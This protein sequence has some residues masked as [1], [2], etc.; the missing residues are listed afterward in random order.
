MS[1]RELSVG[2]GA[3]LERIRTRVG[4]S[5]M[6]AFASLFGVSLSTYRNWLEDGSTSAYVLKRGFVALGVWDV[7]RLLSWSADGEGPAPRWLEDER[8]NPFSPP[9]EHPDGPGGEPAMPVDLAHAREARDQ[10]RQVAQGGGKVDVRVYKALVVL[11]D[12]TSAPEVAA[13]LPSSTSAPR[14]HLLKH[15]PTSRQI[16]PIHGS[17]EANED[18]AA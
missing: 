8:L 3:R 1:R 18:L 17:L 7:E 10:L 15:V 4:I 13:Q 16:W 5:T 9:G 2:Q 6:T 12:L 11:E 14:S